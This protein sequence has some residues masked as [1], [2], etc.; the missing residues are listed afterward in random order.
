MLDLASS[1]VRRRRWL[2]SGLER[3]RNKYRHDWRDIAFQRTLQLLDRAGVTSPAPKVAVHGFEIVRSATAT[4]PAIVAVVH[5]PVD[6]V[7]NRLFEEAGIPWVLL[8]QR[9]EQTKQRAR[10]LGLSGVLEVI[11]QTSDALLALRRSLAEGRT[12]CACVDFAVRTDPAEEAELFVSPAI[13]D[14]AKRTRSPIVYGYSKVTD[15]GAIDVTFG[16]P[17]VD[18]ATVSPEAV[19]EDFIAWMRADRGDRRSWVVRRW[20]PSQPPNDKL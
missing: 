16:L 13:F 19:A 15:D 7:V 5:S 8:A 9:A 10:L 18:P 2:F 6:A 20:A 1:E 3:Y 14:L 11:P 12:V 17:G 4:R